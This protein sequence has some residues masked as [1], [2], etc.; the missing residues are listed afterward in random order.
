MND[1]RLP[2][3]ALDAAIRRELDARARRALERAEPV[4]TVMGAAAGHGCRSFRPALAAAAAIALV[5]ITALL[6]GTADIWLGA[7]A[8]PSPRVSARPVAFPPTVINWPALRRPLHLP[9]LAAGASCP[10][11]P[12]RTIVPG[13]PAM[14]GEGPLYPLTS[15]GSGGTVYYDAPSAAGPQG[16]AVTWVAAPGVSG[17]ALVRGRR[18]DR[19]G[20]LGFGRDEAA[21]LQ[22]APYDAGTPIG[23]A[24]YAA[25]ETDLTVIPAPGCYAYQIDTATTSTV[26]VFAAQPASALAT[27]LRQRPLR[28]PTL[29][30]G[31]ACPTGSPRAVASWVG[32][33]IGPGPVYSI[34]YGP[35]PEAILRIGGSAE[36]G[37]WYLEKILWLAAPGA[38]GPILVRGRQLDGPNLVR[39]GDGATPASDLLLSDVSQVGVSSG[40]FGWR[41]FVAYTRVRA[42]GCY[43]YQVDTAAGSEVIVFAAAP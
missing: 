8:T 3:D 13:L 9:S 14:A 18:L 36:S 37:G 43:A 35:G 23:S 32:P 11:T 10:A 17:P 42:A 16:V 5:L 15:A 6:V 25:L 1:Q 22:L 21:E 29:A 12:T 24:G 20:A 33:A 30:P 19:G 27:V 4:E 39:F 31:A 41:N 28:L 7:S 38:S 34:G 2:D 26:V 40:G